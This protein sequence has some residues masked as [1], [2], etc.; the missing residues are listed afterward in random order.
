MK[1]LFQCIITYI[2]EKIATIKIPP[3]TDTTMI[4]VTIALS[5]SPSDTWGT[6]VVTGLVL[7]IVPLDV[8]VGFTVLLVE[9]TVV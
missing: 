8:E 4:I 1:Q 5:E 3:I 7:V 9:V 6:V 2:R